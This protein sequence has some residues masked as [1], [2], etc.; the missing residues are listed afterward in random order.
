MNDAPVARQNSDRPRHAVRAANR[1]PLRPPI[2]SR[3]ERCGFLLAVSDGRESVLLQK[4]ETAMTFLRECSV[5]RRMAGKAEHTFESRCVHQ[6]GITRTTTFSK[7]A[8]P[9]RCGCNT[10]QKTAVEVEMP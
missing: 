3:T 4:A 7:A 10:K 6:T 8:L 2:K 5:Y 1:V 9:L